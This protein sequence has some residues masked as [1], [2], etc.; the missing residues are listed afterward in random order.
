MV[1]SQ[2]CRAEVD[3]DST[4]EVLAD[5]VS[6]AEDKGKQAESTDTT[7]ESTCVTPADDLHVHIV[8]V[9]DGNDPTDF[10]V[11]QWT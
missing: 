4:R 6:V 11:I 8:T 1:F 5:Q 10:Q 3:L 2:V 7:S 9:S